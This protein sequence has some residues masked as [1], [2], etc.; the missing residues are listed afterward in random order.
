MLKKDFL[1]KKDSDFL[2]WVISFLGYLASILPRISFP[3]SVYTELVALRDAFAQK[4][5]IADT[6]ATRTKLT[7]QAKNTARTALE[8]RI[9]LVVKEYVNY[10]HMVTD[11]DRDGLGL[12]IYKDKRT[13]APVAEKAP[14]LIV[15]AAGPRQVRF[16]FGATKDVKAK[17]EGQHGAEITSVISDTKP[18]EIED[19]TRSSFDT[20]SPLIL[21]FK[22]SERGKTLWFAAR[23]ENTSGEKG[24]WSEIESTIIP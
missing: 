14:V 18:A 15:S 10:N 2:S 5:T 13:P 3:E 20:N 16:D 23:W 24:P 22:E 12:P 1:P 4:L 21:T 19:L 11:E 6:P 17:P 7:V 9:R 8:K